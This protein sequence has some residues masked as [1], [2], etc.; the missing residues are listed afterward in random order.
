MDGTAVLVATQ[1]SSQW[2]C[3]QGWFLDDSSL[4]RLC[5]EVSCRAAASGSQQFLPDSLR[6][7]G[8]AVATW[9]PSSSRKTR[10]KCLRGLRP[11]QAWTGCK[12]QLLVAASLVGVVWESD[13]AGLMRFKKQVVFSTCGRISSAAQLRMLMD[14]WRVCVGSDLRCAYEVCI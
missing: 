11:V 9:P 8:Q 12:W 7:H 1:L 5:T 13:C 2:R 3:G 10:D 14:L 6:Y 4:C